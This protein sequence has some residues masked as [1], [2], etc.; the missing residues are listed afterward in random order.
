MDG[1]EEWQGDSLTMDTSDTG[2]ARINSSPGENIQLD[3]A[4]YGQRHHED[5]TYR[6]EVD[7]HS[8]EGQSRPVTDTRIRVQE[9]DFSH[10]PESQ[11]RES[12]SNSTDELVHW[13]SDSL[14]VVDAS[15]D[16]QGH[17]PNQLSQQQS[18]D[19]MEREQSISGDVP[20]FEG[21]PDPVIESHM[22]SEDPSTAGMMIEPASSISVESPEPTRQAV[23]QPE[24]R[25]RQA[26]EV[27]YHGHSGTPS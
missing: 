6:D 20:S 7:L 11:S 4:I 9:V 21:S 12:H 13:P 26:E 14:T 8:W 27:S 5:D 18:D 1:E 24:S 25:K 22:V 16:W 19:A 3:A 2:E 15:A 10:R 23:F 17:I